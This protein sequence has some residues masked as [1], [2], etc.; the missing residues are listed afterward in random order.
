MNNYAPD[1]WQP[2]KL[3]VDG[4]S[5]YKIMGTWY[6]GYLG[7]D[8]WRLSSGVESIKE[9]DECYEVLNTSG[10]TYVCYKGCEGMGGYTTG[11]YESYVKEA[12]ASNGKFTIELVDVNELISNFSA[13]DQ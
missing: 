3:T 6:G 12:E 13:N 8:S 9:L 10:S 2:V 1:R 11:V 4:Q 7:S 5:I